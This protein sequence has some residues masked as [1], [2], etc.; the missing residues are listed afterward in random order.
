MFFHQLNDRFSHNCDGFSKTFKL[1]YKAFRA[2]T[3]EELAK[4][5]DDI[6]AIYVK[7]VAERR[8]KN[9][10]LTS[11][12]SVLL[13][14][15]ESYG[16]V[17]NIWYHRLELST[18]DVI[19]YSI[20]V[21]LIT[22]IQDGKT[23]KIRTLLSCTFSCFPWTKYIDHMLRRFLPAA[24]IEPVILAFYTLGQ[25]FSIR[26]S[27][28]TYKFDVLSLLGSAGVIGLTHMTSRFLSNLFQEQFYF[29]PEW[30]ITSIL[31]TETAPFIQRIARFGIGDGLV[32]VF[33]KFME[34]LRYGRKP[35]PELPLEFDV[36]DSLQC[37]IC[38]DLIRDPVES[39]GFFFCEECLKNWQKRGGRYN[40]EC[41][42]ENISSDLISGCTILDIV[43]R[44][45][46]RL[47]LKQLENAN[48]EPKFLE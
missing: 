34:V 26:F 24:A 23:M 8:N 17:S 45:Y 44:K 42:N 4:L 21:P 48:N 18:L 11:A 9:K 7:R 3:L 15:I 37:G 5:G 1:Y 40:P 46:H 43:A 31:A 27:H 47:A 36:A 19:E 16:I 6:K 30:I 25:V 41:P 39:I 10:Q 22:T 38:H 35:L 32:W 33:E 29:I 14:S 12:W 20:A 2:S 28:G 13:T